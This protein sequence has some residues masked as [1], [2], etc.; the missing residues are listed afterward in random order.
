MLLQ[1]PGHRRTGVQIRELHGWTLC[2]VMVLAWLFSIS[3]SHHHN[4][5]SLLTAANALSHRV[6]R[7]L[8]IY[9]PSTSQKGQMT[10]PLKVE[11]SFDLMDFDGFAARGDRWLVIHWLLKAMAARD[12]LQIQAGEHCGT[13][14]SAVTGRRDEN[15]LSP[16]PHPP[17]E[18]GAA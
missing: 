2:C 9:S 16:L 14:W 10:F 18:Y 11:R 13:C 4:A 7:P 15:L 8:F 5:M 1:R 12:C 6:I 3:L 17:G